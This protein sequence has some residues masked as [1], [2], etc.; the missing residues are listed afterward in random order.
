MNYGL[1]L[2]KAAFRVK[3]E[4]LE[5]KALKLE[6]EILERDNY[7]DS[8]E[9]QVQLLEKQNKELNIENEA[10][11]KENQKIKEQ[12]EQLQ[13]ESKK[14][15]RPP[16]PLALKVQCKK[17]INNIPHNSLNKSFSKS[18]SISEHN[19]GQHNKS[20]LNNSFEAEKLKSSPDGKFFF[21]LI[22]YR[23][24]AEQFKEFINNVKKFYKKEMS[25]KD[26]AEYAQ[27][28]FGEENQDLL[29]GLQL[30]LFS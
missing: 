21:T 19:F 30:M 12:C 9:Q 11:D 4:E 6:D 2:I 24:S 7:L 13:K 27:K 1:S 17:R 14:L 16:V 3:Y 28:L 10:L 22:K 23:L 5:V 15:M 26:L 18:S 8:L 29:E 20:V 25:K